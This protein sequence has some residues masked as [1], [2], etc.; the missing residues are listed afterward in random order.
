MK[1]PEIF[2]FSNIEQ[3]KEKYLR[4]ELKSKEW[5]LMLHEIG[6]DIIEIPFFTNEFCD[7]MVENLKEY[8]TQKMDQWGSL[9]EMNYINEL[10]MYDVFR[11]LLNEYMGEITNHKWKS[12]GNKWEEMDIQTMIFT[13]KHNQDLRVRHDF[14]MFTTYLKLDSDSV[15]GEMVFPKYKTVFQPKQGHM[16]IYPGRV[17]HRYGVRLI[18]EGERK[19]MVTH[20]I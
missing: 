16:Y 8:P 1:Y 15:G 17:T 4:K 7:K 5:D 12:Y 19:V 14:T 6:P 9:L 11:G 13:M 18:S 10:G 3:W 20:C 2:D